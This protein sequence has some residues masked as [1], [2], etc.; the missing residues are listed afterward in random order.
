MVVSFCVI[1]CLGYVFV[2]WEVIEF[3]KFFKYD[4]ILKLLF[5]EF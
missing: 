4:N 3:D 1:I 5:V 2:K